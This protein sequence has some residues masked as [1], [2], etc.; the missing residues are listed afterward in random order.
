MVL[1]SRFGVQGSGNGKVVLI[2]QQA[3]C[4][5][6]SCWLGRGAQGTGNAGLFVQQG[7]QLL[8]QEFKGQEVL[9]R[10]VREKADPR[11]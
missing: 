3:C 5:A 6:G 2:M 9:R 10:V 4:R 7:W 1:W 8:L 11:V